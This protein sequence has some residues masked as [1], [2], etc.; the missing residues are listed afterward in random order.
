MSGDGSTPTPWDVWREPTDTRA[1]AIAELTAQVE[2]TEPFAGAVWLLNAGG[3]CP[4]TTG[5]GPASEAN[6]RRIVAAVNATA[7]IP[8]EALEAG[9]VAKL[10]EALEA[11][12]GIL[13]AVSTDWE[14]AQVK[15][16]EA[17]ALTKG[18]AA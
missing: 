12:D 7:D 11:A 14:A 9:V 2:A 15:V 1:A 10:V 18:E 4:A 17:L 6:A 16:I 3:I 13:R 5:C 8:V